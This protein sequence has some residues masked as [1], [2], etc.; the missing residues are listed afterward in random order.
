M[1]K[2][3]PLSNFARE[4]NRLIEEIIN[5][6]PHKETFGKILWSRPCHIILENSIENLN[7][8]SISTT[9]W[10]SDTRELYMMITRSRD[11]LRD[12]EMFFS[13]NPLKRL[14]STVGGFTMM[15]KYKEVV[16]CVADKVHRE[17]IS[18]PA[19]FHVK[20][21]SS[22]SLAKVSHV[23]AWAIRRVLRDHQN[24]VPANQVTKQINS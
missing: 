18:E 17:S 7:K 22:E 14:Q 20:G 13:S 2:A 1:K 11:Y 12:L 4:K 24:Y 8:L 21:T 3:G 16:K 15:E 23:G 10:S 6:N 9:L 19:A 5:E